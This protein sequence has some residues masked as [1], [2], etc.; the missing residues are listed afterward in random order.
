[1]PTGCLQ[2]PT[3]FAFNIPKNLQISRQV[4]VAKV[5]DLLEIWTPYPNTF[6][7]KRPG[8][9]RSTFSEWNQSVEGRFWH[10]GGLTPST[11]I[12]F[13]CNTPTQVLASWPNFSLVMPLS[14]FSVLFSVILAGFSLSFPI[15]FVSVHV[16]P[17]RH[18]LDLPYFSWSSFL[19]IG[20]SVSVKDSKL[21]DC[22]ECKNVFP[23]PVQ[24][25]PFLH[26]WLLQMFL[27]CWSLFSWASFVSWGAEL[28]TFLNWR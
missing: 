24:K 6:C 27:A 3:A 23:E 10:T 22:T 4:A 28:K 1:M 19:K 7:R 14:L 26:S 11:L 18:L 5:L 2:L 15:G 13:F 9:K 8:N 20:F 16:Q 25:P 12:V 21:K 17:P